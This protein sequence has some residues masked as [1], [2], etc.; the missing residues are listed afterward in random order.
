MASKPP[1]RLNKQEARESLPEEARPMFDQ[2]CEDTLLWSNY[3]Y[4]T[5]LISYSIIKELVECG[6]RKTQQ[7][8]T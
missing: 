5:S 7:P 1:K 6:W 8:S 3:Y 2:L 4:G